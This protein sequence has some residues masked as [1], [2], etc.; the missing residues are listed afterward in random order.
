MQVEINLLPQ[1]KKIVKSTRKVTILMTVV[2]ML[3]MIV[4][5][6]AT[7]LANQKVKALEVELQ[8]IQEQRKVIEEQIVQMKDPSNTLQKEIKALTE[9]R[10][11]TTDVVAD[12]L[13]P[14]NKDAMLNLTYANDGN[15]LLLGKFKGLEDIA[16]YE[17]NLIKTEGISEV[18]VIKITKNS[19]LEGEIVSG[20]VP[21]FTEFEVKYAKEAYRPQG[22]AN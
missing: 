9:E 19:E 17:Q 1:K 7:Y 2:F 6:G 5:G 21:Y 16:T 8:G 22:G 3:G 15:V 4:I 20:D 13:Q 10:I 12:V 18:K 14:L 11:D